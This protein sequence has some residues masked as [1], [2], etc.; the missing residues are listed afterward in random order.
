MDKSSQ[1]HIDSVIKPL[2]RYSNVYRDKLKSL[3]QTGAR[4]LREIAEDFYNFF[5]VLPSHQSIQNWLQTGATKRI[6]NIKAP[7]S[8]YY[9]YDE[10]HIKIKGKWNFR[11][12]LYDHI[13]NMPVAEEIAPKE[14]KTAIHNFIKEITENIPFYA[15]T[16]DHLLE[17]KTITDS[18]RV[19]HQQCIFHLYKM[20]GVSV[21]KILKDKTI[22]RQVKIRLVLYF[23]E[24]KNIFRTFN[25]KTAIKRLE[26]L[27]EKFD[28]I[29]KVLQ[30]F[31]IK[32]IIPDFQR[33]TQFLRLFV[34]SLKIY[35]FQF[36][37]H[38]YISRTSNPDENYYRQTDPE[39]VKRKYKKPEG[40]LNYASLKMQYWTKKHGKIPNTH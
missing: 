10:Q 8:G 7:Y 13:L 12:T 14:T 2:H 37:R 34:A 32:K 24:I 33:L 4:S 18:F 6:T 3:I 9:C 19:I 23:T 29:P 36:M 22:P 15:L 20:I 39:Q 27:L 11:L 21:Y 40:F 38:P 5:G 31:I 16:T 26:T 30:G 28:D 17:Y 25:E 1:H 35:D